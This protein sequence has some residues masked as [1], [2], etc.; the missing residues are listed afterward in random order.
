VLLLILDVLRLLQARWGP[1]L[2][3]TAKIAWRP[4]VDPAAR[5]AITLQDL[6]A[7]LIIPSN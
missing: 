3:V 6:L 1:P 4:T 2:R 7:K 5:D